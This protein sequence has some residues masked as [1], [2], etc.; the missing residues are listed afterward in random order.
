AESLLRITSKMKILETYLLLSLD[1]EFKQLHIIF[2]NKLEI[3][4]DI[5]DA[6]NQGDYFD[7]FYEDVEVDVLFAEM[8]FFTN[9]IYSLFKITGDRYFKRHIYPSVDL[10]LNEESLL[11]TDISLLR[12]HLENESEDNIENM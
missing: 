6:L 7:D 11:E 9:S 4:K 8:R 5:N 1:S 2:Q 10:L 12:S 3:N